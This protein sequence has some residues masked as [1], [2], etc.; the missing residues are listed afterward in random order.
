MA[1][2]E[3]RDN[4]KL[5]SFLRNITEAGFTGIMWGLWVYM[6]L[7]VLNIVL[8]VF[9]VRYFHIAII[10]KAGYKEVLNLVG[11]MGWA[12]LTV[13]LIMR[14]W[15][16]YNYRKFGRNDRR[17]GKASSDARQIAEFHHMTVETVRDLQ[18]KKEIVWQTKEEGD[19]KRS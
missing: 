2:I 9:G 15:G 17:K 5:R 12:V 1:E 18:S 8:W 14:L 7:P 19:V 6:I 11:K 3:I 13:F 4:P 16:F 10:E